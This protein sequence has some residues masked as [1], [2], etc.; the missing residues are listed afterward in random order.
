MT[1]VQTCAL[2][3]LF[4]L[5]LVMLAATVL[6]RFV[7]GME[8]LSG[9]LGSVAALRVPLVIYAAALLAGGRFWTP[10]TMAIGAGVAIAA[11]VAATL[12]LDNLVQRLELEPIPAAFRGE[13]VRLLSAGLVALAFSGVE[14]AFFGILYI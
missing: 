1:G 13:P 3:I 5:L 11:Y 6:T 10:A 7:P 9:Y 2:P 8:P 14:T 4:L 12:F